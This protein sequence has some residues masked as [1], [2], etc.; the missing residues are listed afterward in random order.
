MRNEDILW[1]ALRYAELDAP[2]AD[3]LGAFRPGTACI[4]RKK[5]GEGG[6]VLLRNQRRRRRFQ[7]TRRLSTA[8][9]RSAAHRKC[10]ADAGRPGRRSRRC[11]YEQDRLNFIALRNP[12]AEAAVSLGLRPAHGLSRTGDRGAAGKFPFR[13]VFAT[14]SPSNPNNRPPMPLIYRS[15]LP[16]GLIVLWKIDESE[17]ELR[18]LCTPARAHLRLRAP[19]DRE[20]SQRV[21]G[22]ARCCRETTPQAETGYDPNGAPVLK[23][24]EYIGVSHTKGYAAVIIAK[25]PC[26]VDIELRNRNF[27]KAAPKYLSPDERQ[28]FGTEGDLPGKIWC[29]KETLY[30]WAR[31]PETDFLR[32]IRID[33]VDP[34]YGTLQGN[35]PGIRRH[36]A[37]LFE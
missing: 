22:M 3:T 37:R 11:A 34:V 20:P 14:C 24:G 26:A 5:I 8:A 30:K 1:G 25:T 12:G 19:H 16:N 27:L 31:I 18:S 7:K 33:A 10:R 13:P 28:R 21:A 4:V 9:R 35:D 17:T 2:D 29:A 36:I 23:S 6:P 15:E 32:D